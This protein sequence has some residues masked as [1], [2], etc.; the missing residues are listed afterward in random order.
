MKKAHLV[1]LILTSLTIAYAQQ[2]LVITRQ[3]MQVTAGPD[4]VYDVDVTV[5]IPSEGANLAW[6]YSGISYSGIVVVSNEA[7]AN[8]AFP[9]AFCA[10]KD[11][12]ETIA[13]GRGFYYDEYLTLNDSYFGGIGI[14]IAD[15]RYGIGDVTMNPA[16]SLNLP[17]QNIAYAAPRQIMKFPF[18]YGTSMT[19]SFVRE[20]NFTLTIGAYGLNNA[21][22]TKRMYMTQTDSVV[23]WGTL[24]LPGPNGPTPRFNVLLVKRITVEVDSFLLNGAAAPQMLLD[25]FQITQGQRTEQGRHLFYRANSKI[26]LFSI[27][28]EDQ[29]FTNPVTAYFDRTAAMLTSVEETPGAAPRAAVYPNPSN[30]G[31]FNIS[32]ENGMNE[33]VVRNLL[34]Q[35]VVRMQALSS[36]VSFSLPSACPPGMY[37]YQLVDAAGSLRSGGKL[38]FMK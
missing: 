8:P 20:G 37:T 35:V 16:D 29:T 18:T 26:Y 21:I 6:N 30:D 14:G 3:N 25:A 32:V 12:F 31:S 24:V 15:Q 22:G 36:P 2:P 7:A 13:I 17:Q 38:L 19:S 10:A 4:T 28:Y 33:L 9:S 1:F 11:Y 34:G 27:T 23:G 5:N